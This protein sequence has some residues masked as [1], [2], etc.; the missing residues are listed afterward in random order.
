M[1]LLRVLEDSAVT[2]IGSATPVKLDSRLVVATNNHP[3]QLVKD[4]T[5]RAD[6]YYRLAVTER[7]NPSLEVRGEVDKI[8]IFKVFIASVV[9]RPGSRLCPTS[10]TGWPTPSPTP[11][12]PATCATCATSPSGSA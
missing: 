5:F 4:G 1:K 10:R 12:S 7:K 6:L 11:I 2:R 3:Q 9:V 8:A